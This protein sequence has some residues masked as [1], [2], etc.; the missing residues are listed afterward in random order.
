MENCVLSGDC[1]V[2]IDNAESAAPASFDAVRNTWRGRK[3]LEVVVPFFQLKPHELRTNRNLFSVDHFFVLYW[4]FRG[5]RSTEH[6]PI[7]G[8]R[9]MLQQSFD[10]REQENL[11]PA[12]PHFLS[13]HS[14]RQPLI[15]MNNAPE[16]VAA[17][18]T[19]WNRPGSGS[20]QGAAPDALRGKFGANESLVGPGHDIPASSKSN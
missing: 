7:Q 1:C 15:P 11:Y 13:W 2:S 18:E 17:W 8:I 10:W 19:F 5:P 20:Q 3:G 6:P 12:Q 4:P 16:T 14:P 9:R